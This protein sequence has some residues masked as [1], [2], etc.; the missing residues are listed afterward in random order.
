MQLH[1]I[2]GVIYLALLIVLG[3][4]EEVSR[5]Q[6]SLLSSRIHTELIFIII[7]IIIINNSLEF[8]QSS[9]YVL[10]GVIFQPLSLGERCIFSPSL[11]FPQLMDHRY[12]G[13]EF[14]MKG[15]IAM[16]N[17]I[18]QVEFWSKVP[19]CCVVQPNGDVPDQR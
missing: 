2:C 10:R 13:R 11:S 17:Y 19:A 12:V 4:N 6:T 8:I 14:Q 18:D 1:F 15:V 3:R 7:F 5:Q 9:K 16:W